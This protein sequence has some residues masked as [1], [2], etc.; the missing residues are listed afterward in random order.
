M[1]SWSWR[2][3]DFLKKKQLYTRFSSNKNLKDGEHH[4]PPCICSKRSMQFC[5]RLPFHL[6]KFL[7]TQ[8]LKL[9][10]SHLSTVWTMKSSVNLMAPTSL[11]N[12]LHM[13]PLQK[14]INFI[15]KYM[16]SIR[17]HSLIA[18]SAT[19]STTGSWAIGHDSHPWARRGPMHPHSREEWRAQH[20]FR[21]ALWWCRAASQQQDHWI[22]SII[23]RGERASPLQTPIC[24]S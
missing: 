13:N 12:K 14:T 8:S 9:L 5:F 11:W 1:N 18:S 3:I 20:R 17:G 4:E 23:M 16:K 19:F 7:Y 2:D 10:I 21:A 24:K 15:P 6:L 22:G